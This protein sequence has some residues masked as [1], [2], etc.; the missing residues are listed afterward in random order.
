[1][2]RLRAALFLILFVAAHSAHGDQRTEDAQLDAAFA[3]EYEPQKM[4]ALEPAAI[5]ASGGR[6]KREGATLT[7]NIAQG[8]AVTLTNDESGCKSPR[9]EHSK[10]Y[11]FTLLADLPS[12]HA[13]LVAQSYDEGGK[14]VMIDDRTGRRTDFTELPRF[15]SDGTLLLVISN[16]E[17]SDAGLI[18]LWSR[19]GDTAKKLWEIPDSVGAEQAEFVAW[20]DDGI[21][22]DLSFPQGDDKPQVHRKAKL[23]RGKSGWEL[24]FTDGK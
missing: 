3:A 24:T 18:Q 13:F 22:L 9:P 1:M 2:L 11:D 16:D 23:A 19:E 20:N 6:A 12:R 21:Q 7:L 15:S 14:V 4:L 17:E 10:C 8:P 5:A